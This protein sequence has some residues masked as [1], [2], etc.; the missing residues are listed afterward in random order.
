MTFAIKKLNNQIKHYEWGS[1]ELIP[2]FLNLENRKGIPYAEMWMGTHIGAPSQVE[3]DGRQSDLSKISGQLPF[4]FKLIAVQKPLSIQAHPNKKQAEEGFYREE[5]QGLSIKSPMRNYK[6]TNHKPEILCAISPFTMMAGF[7][8]PD[9]ISKSLEMILSTTPQLKELIFPLL[10]ALENGS[11]SDFF[12]LL[13]NFSN[14][15]R[16]YLGSFIFDKEP[17]K[18]SGV[19]SPAQWKLMKSLAAQ[20]PHDIA[21]ISPLY[22]NLLTLQPG[23]A[24]YIPSGIL[25]AY[26]SGFGVELMT[27]SDNVLRGGLTPKHIDIKELM[28][29]LYFV[30]FAPQII[31]PPSGAQWFC[32]HTPCGEFSLAFMRGSGE[33]IFPEKG[34]AVCLVTEGELET[35]GQTLKKGESFY[36]P[37]AD[38]NPVSFNGNFSLF[39][40]CAGETVNGK[41]G[42]AQ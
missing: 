4:L 16:E 33:K 24:V 15:E 13:F 42:G 10:C 18:Y 34:P 41:D 40:A 27:S 6:D 17:D 21:V 26:I 1:N 20:Y 5:E 38:G 37:K 9:V 23:Q 22:L 32:Y 11:F 2:Q 12:R 28:N 14:I 3:L 19:I 31:T 36:V 7:R 25:H 8:E 35:C 29:I 39:A 30:P